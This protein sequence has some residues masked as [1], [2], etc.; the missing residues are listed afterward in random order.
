[1]WYDACC[2]GVMDVWQRKWSA[3]PLELG[4]TLCRI[5]QGSQIPI[6]PCDLPPVFWAPHRHF[7]WLDRH[8]HWDTPH[9]HQKLKIFKTKTPTSMHHH[10]QPPRYP[11]WET[12]HDLGDLSFCLIQSHPENNI[13]TKVLYR[14]RPTFFY[15]VMITA[16]IQALV[17]SHLE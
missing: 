10:Y 4:S 13:A 6:S 8:L 12:Q 17:L 2:A 7:R 16:R 1:M 11:S 5:S 14:R 15:I 9:I 3:L